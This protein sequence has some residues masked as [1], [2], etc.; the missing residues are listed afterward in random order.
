MQ[1]HTPRTTPLHYAISVMTLPPPLT[2]VQ[3]LPETCFM[4]TNAYLLPTSSPEVPSICTLKGPQRE[5]IGTKPRYFFPALFP[6]F[7]TKELWLAK[8]WNKATEVSTL[9]ATYK[10]SNLYTLTPLTICCLERS[11]YRGLW[12][13]RAIQYSKG[14]QPFLHPRWR[15]WQICG[16]MYVQS[17]PAGRISQ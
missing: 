3:W 13:V 14:Q 9:N 15:L 8:L 16:A 5:R 11:M 2:T 4:S 17:R 10:L 7:S 12:I 1:G 6:L